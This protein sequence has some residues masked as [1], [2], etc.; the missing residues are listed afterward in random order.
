MTSKPSVFRRKNGRAF[1]ALRPISFQTGF[2]A[3]PEGSVLIKQGN[4]HVLCNVSVEQGVPAWMVAQN[5]KGGWITAEYA[6][7]PRATH[8]R[9]P[10]ETSRPNSRSQEI[11][12]LIGRSLRAGFHL[13]LLPEITCTVD[14]DVLQ[15]DGGTR[16]AAVTGGYVAMLLAL[17]HSLPGDR[18][19]SDV[20]ISQIAAV[21][22]GL[23]QGQIL[24]DLDYDED[25][26][27]DADVNIVMDNA[28]AFIE[29]QGTAEKG[30]IPRTVFDSILDSAQSG[31]EQLF[32]AQLVCLAAQGIEFDS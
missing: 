24:L 10:R 8:Q 3:Y 20:V 16:T 18:K 15:A 4:T 14:C 5:L 17:S 23:Q 29:I 25:R 31:I 32:E 21:S 2:S 30:S 26:A 27:V 1:S 6:M 9:S 19:L 22:V 12:R 11:R 13:D 7:L 28:D